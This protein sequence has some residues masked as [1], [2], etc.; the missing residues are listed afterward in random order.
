[1]QQFQPLAIGLNIHRNLARE[2][3]RKNLITHFDSHPNLITICSYGYDKKYDPPPE[4]SQ[5]K[6]TN[7]VSFS[8][9]PHDE[10]ANEKGSTIRRQS[11]SYQ[12]NLSNFTNNCKTPNSFSLLSALRFL[13]NQG[14]KSAT[15]QNQEW[16][17]GDVTF[18][19]LANRTAGYQNLKGLVSQVLLNYRANPKPAFKVTLQEVLS[20]KITSDLVKDKIVL[21]AHTSEVSKD[22]SN[23]KW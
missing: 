12:P 16:R 5:E 15:T 7:Q 3:G 23:P 2:P 18:P 19:R 13:E 9:L 4:F 8:N 22:Y 14:I 20:W 1:M 21:I 11:L 10:T 17:I 6:L